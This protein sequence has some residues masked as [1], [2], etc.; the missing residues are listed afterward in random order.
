VAAVRCVSRWREESSDD[1]ELG[2]WFSRKGLGGMT[3]AIHHTMHYSPILLLPLLI[4]CG[5]VMDEASFVADDSFPFVVNESAKLPVPPVA[6]P[7]GGTPVGAQGGYIEPKGGVIAGA[8]LRLPDEVAQRAVVNFADAIVPGGALENGLFAVMVEGE[9]KKWHY[10]GITGTQIS[11][12]A[13]RK[14]I[15]ALSPTTGKWEAYQREPKLGLFVI[16]A[17]R[18]APAQRQSYM[19]E[20]TYR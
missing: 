7:G 1:W 20:L 5:E 10:T 15:G 19:V 8:V 12:L 14:V 11:L 2:P 3:V 17:N 16:P 6:A 18:Q 9:D 4:G 13:D